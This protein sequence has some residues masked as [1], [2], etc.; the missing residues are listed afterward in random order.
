MSELNKYE[1]IYQEVE[2]ILGSPVYILGALVGY[3]SEITDHK[4]GLLNE[5]AKTF[6]RDDVDNGELRTILINL[7]RFKTHPIIEDTANTLADMLR[8]K[9]NSKFI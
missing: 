8:K 1:Q 9:S 5:Y 2:N 6:I 3:E 7:K 4:L